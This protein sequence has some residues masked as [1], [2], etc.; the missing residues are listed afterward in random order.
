M[1]E[2]GQHLLL[3]LGEVAAGDDCDLHDPQEL[4]EQAQW[5]A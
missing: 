2:V 1:A 3:E 4:A 5:S